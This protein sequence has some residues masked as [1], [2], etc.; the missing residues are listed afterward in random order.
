M[1]REKQKKIEQDRLM[2]ERLM[3]KQES[4]EEELPEESPVEAHNRTLVSISN[5]ISITR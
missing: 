2:Q 1:E 4:F 5:Q 3:R